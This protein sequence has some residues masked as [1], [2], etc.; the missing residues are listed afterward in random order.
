[1]KS[2]DEL[3]SD[4]GQVYFQMKT[5]LSLFTGALVLGLGQQ[6][7]AETFCGDRTEITYGG[8]S[9]LSGDLASHQCYEIGAGGIGTAGE[10]IGLG[11]NVN[12]L[13]GSKMNVLGHLMDSTVNGGAE[14]WIGKTTR[15][16]WDGYI[17]NEPALGVNIDVKSGGLI[18]VLDGGTLKDSFLNGGMVYVSN[19]GSADDPGI[20][21]NNTVNSGG[22]LF[23]YLGGKSEDTIINSGGN[24]YV[25]QNGFSNRSIV[26]TG[27]FQGVYSGGVATATTIKSDGLQQ[28]GR[29]GVAEST[30]V[31]A[32]AQQYV[33][34]EGVANNATVYGKQWVFVNNS[35]SYGAGV[36]N[37]T[38]VYEDGQQIIQSGGAS[39][40]GVQLHDRAI[41]M[42][43]AGSS[44]TNVTVNDSA[45]S[46]LGT[47]AQ[48]LG[49]TQ[50]NGQGQLQ[51]T[52]AQGDTGAY[53]QQV[54]LNGTD[55]ALLVIANTDDTDSARIGQ[56]SGNGM[57]RFI[58]GTDSNTGET[59]YSRLNV[60][61][62]SGNMH[63]FFSTSIQDGRSDMLIVR[64]AS[65]VHQVTVSDSGREI[66]LPGETTLDLVVDQSGGAQFNLA[67]LDGVNINA[68][69][70][71]TYMY[72]LGQ[73]EDASLTRDASV[74]KVWYL[75]TGIDDVNR[76]VPPG[77]SVVPPVSIP[78]I[79]QTTPSTDAVLAM[80]NVPAMMFNNELN[81]LR[82]RRGSLKDNEGQ[83]GVWGRVIADK[84]DVDS[85]HVNF[86]LEQAGFEMGVDKIFATE[87]GKV[88]VGVFGT[89]SNADVK[90]NR[91]GTSKVDSYGAGVYA[92]YFDN[93]GI[94]VDG[95]L[96]YNRYNNEL[97]AV[98][99]NG[100]GIQGDYKQNAL[101]A[102][103]E[104]GYNTMVFS[105]IWAEPYARVSYVQVGGKDIALSNGMYAHIG[106]Q[107]SLVTELGVSVG[108]DFAVGGQHVIS[109]YV[110]AAWVH[111]YISGNSTRINGLYSFDTDLSG[112][113]GKL[114]V[115]VNANL[116]QG[117]AAVFGELN[118]GAGNK[119]DAPIQFNIGVRYNF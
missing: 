12:L 115:G 11:I 105:D 40:I 46:W 89:Y 75:H 97:R 36:A 87:R 60:E 62:M 21:I 5:T 104:L 78:G 23:A 27:G 101:G 59:I 72:A 66:T 64:N 35:A 25:Q 84:N 99:T 65:G 32:G 61:N 19:T 98:S 118:Y 2:L 91:G 22:Q 51:L 113:M 38:S 29:R 20:S 17:A 68:V 73:R 92:T 74:G 102:S 67:T 93:N 24:E 4:E 9:V 7:W 10:Y 96:K 34:D 28:V 94:Y 80:A 41:Q 103:L 114:G 6:A 57:V 18:R 52:A 108:K 77:E 53:A 63:L 95:V 14:V 37:N 1:M 83:A 85:N 58:T 107:D 13:D 70:G 90:H 26:N 86:K 71:G 69:D 106:N 56:L 42:I 82:F 30:M 111:E 48:I 8:A 55:T 110:K 119:V 116:F 3:I 50:V 81:N 45:K 79:V 44:A 109:P 33:Y 16:A 112:N 43:S 15:I 47:G 117:R 31:E 54:N 100:F 88:F 39:A 76:V 49:T